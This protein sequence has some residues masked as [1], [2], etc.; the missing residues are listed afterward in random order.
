V[1]RVEMNGILAL[2]KEIVIAVR[3][4]TV[5]AQIQRMISTPHGEM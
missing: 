4:V 5:Y 3:V 1:K 2:M